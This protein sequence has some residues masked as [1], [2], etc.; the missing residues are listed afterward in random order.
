MT[1]REVSLRASTH[2][3]EPTKFA[4]RISEYTRRDRARRAFRRFLPVFGTGCALLFIPPHVLW[5]LGFTLTGSV[6]AL[7]R[8]REEREIHE[9]RGRCPGCAT[10]Q[11]L[12]PPATLPAIQRCPGCG[13]FLKLEEA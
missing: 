7:Q 8:Y 2:G 13:A 6:L 1:V 12:E 3:A 5:L 10:D 4:A 11:S 9:I